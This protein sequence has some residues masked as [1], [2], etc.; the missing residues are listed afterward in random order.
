MEE[1]DGLMEFVDEA[2]SQKYHSRD[3]EDEGETTKKKTMDAFVGK[4]II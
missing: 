1:F 3:Y 2:F 4:E